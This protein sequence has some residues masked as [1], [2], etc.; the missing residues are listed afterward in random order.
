MR[1]RVRTENLTAVDTSATFYRCS[2]ANWPTSS[3]I[4]ALANMILRAVCVPV[5][6]MAFNSLCSFWVRETLYVAGLPMCVLFP[7]C[8]PGACPKIRCPLL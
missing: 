8:S 6:V 5:L 7:V 2:S 4:K 1:S 3:N